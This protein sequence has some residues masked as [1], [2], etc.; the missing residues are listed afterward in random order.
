MA[1]ILVVDDEP[2]FR[3]FVA[4]VLQ[5]AG[6][7]TTLAADGLEA[8]E[9]PGPFD[10]LLT[11]LMMPRMTGGELARRMR[12]RNPVVKVLYLTGQREKLFKEKAELLAGAAFLAKPVSPEVLEDTVARLLSESIVPVA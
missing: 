11:D 2:L 3:T 10:L 4:S 5:I 7:Q 1:R 12:Q 6:H 9:S 8:L